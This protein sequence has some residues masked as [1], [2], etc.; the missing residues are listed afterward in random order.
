[1]NVYWAE[2][3]D[4]NSTE[5]QVQL[6]KNV[7]TPHGLILDL[8]CGTGRH[9]IPL[10]KEG[11]DVVG[12]DISPNLLKIAKT[13]LSSVQLIRA[14][15]QHLSFKPQAFAAAVSMDT[16]LGYLPTEQDDAE[17]L[18][19][20]HQTLHKD[21]IL[22]VD[23]FNRSQL[24]EKYAAK[25][26]V[27]SK[28]RE[29]PSFFLSQKRTVNKN[30]LKLRDLWTVSD[31]ADGKTRVFRHI[32]RLYPSKVLHN[33]LEQAGFAVTR[34]IGDYEGQQFNLTSKRLILVANPKEV[35]PTNVS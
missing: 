29:Y 30:G 11:Y 31:K 8:A 4:Q 23:V 6:I 16:S 22:I 26:G 2:V 25:N 34:T 17:S 35:L 19:E 1:M 32:V 15:M 20:L 28:Q 24:K 9:S 21:G 18:L 3:A 14:D 12:L 27:N 33:L 5:K 13:R 7:L 10:S